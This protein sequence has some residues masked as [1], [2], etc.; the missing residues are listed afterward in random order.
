[1]SWTGHMC[2]LPV[3]GCL[4]LRREDFH[5]TK[6]CK[7]KTPIDTEMC[8]PSGVGFAAAHYI[9][10]IEE[11][12]QGVQADQVVQHV[13]KTEMYQVINIVVWGVLLW[14]V[15]CP[16][17]AS[18]L[19]HWQRWLAPTAGDSDHDKASKENRWMIGCCPVRSTK[20]KLHS[21]KTTTPQVWW[22]SWCCNILNIHFP[23]VFTFLRPSPMPWSCSVCP[24][25][26]NWWIGLGACRFCYTSMMLKPCVLHLH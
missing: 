23:P 22:E 20:H 10:R 2:L 4:K 21:L 17:C 3:I 6:Q 14:Q 18:S 26:T 1:M 5:W 7:K 19:T 25:T 8:T 24:G 15:T 9:G 13:L 16:G 11:F 12:I